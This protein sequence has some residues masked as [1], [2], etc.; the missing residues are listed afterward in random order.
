MK[1]RQTK[2]NPGRVIKTNNWKIQKTENLL[3][4]QMKPLMKSSAP[5]F[6]AY[7]SGIAIIRNQERRKKIKS[8]M[9]L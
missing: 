5:D 2:N 8:Y 9:S 1:A 6:S 7:K 3:P 4:I